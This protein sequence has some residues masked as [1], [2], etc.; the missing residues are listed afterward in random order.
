MRL[1][2]VF[3]G[4]DS[5]YLVNGQASSSSIGRLFDFLAKLAVEGD[6]A[7]AGLAS[8]LVEAL[9]LIIGRNVAVESDSRS[10]M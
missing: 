10:S 4:F 7:L 8:M 9:T 5:F 3:T 2:T 1:D 6:R